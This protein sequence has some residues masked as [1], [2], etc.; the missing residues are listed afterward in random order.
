MTMSL[1][2]TAIVRSNCGKRL[3]IHALIANTSL[4]ALT[5]PDGVRTTAGWPGVKSS[6]GVRS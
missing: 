4:P 1:D 5:L 2:T 6:I 3:A